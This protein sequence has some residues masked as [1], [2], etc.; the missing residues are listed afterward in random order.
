MVILASDNDFT[1]ELYAMTNQELTTSVTELTASAA[2]Q[3][4][5]INAIIAAA[6]GAADFAAFKAAMGTIT[7]VTRSFQIEG[8]TEPDSRSIETDEQPVKKTTTRKK[9]TAKADTQEEV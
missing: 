9:S 5:A 4:T 6:T 3:K 1:Y 8:T 7:P 2:D